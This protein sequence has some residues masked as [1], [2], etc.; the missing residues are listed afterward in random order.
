MRRDDG[1]DMTDEVARRQVLKGLGLLAAARLV[2]AAVVAPATRPAVTVKF[3]ITVNQALPF[4]QIL[5]MWEAAEGLG[6]DG[7]FVFDHFMGMSPG[8]PEQERQQEAWTLLAALA[9]RTR[10]LR[11]GLLVNGCT[12]RHPAIVAKMAATVDQ[13][14]RG[15]LIL[16]LGAGWAER[17]HKAYGIPFYTKAGRARRLGEYV[18]V[19]KALF[20]EERVT[21]SGKY[22][23]LKDAVLEPKPVQKPHPPILIGGS[24]KKIILPIAAK[25]AQ[26]WHFGVP[27]KDPT[28]VKQFVAAFDELC[29]S[30]GR[31]P[32]EVVKA[33]SFLL[34]DSEQAAKDVRALLPGLI[35]AGIT[36]FVLLP[37]NAAASNVTLLRKFARDFF[38]KFRR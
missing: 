25:Y 35:A 18:E 2:P 34:P 15:R 33:T 5:S 21:Y 3:S 11:V 16:G 28:V 24:G 20:V 38:P 31:N 14:S 22:F 29:R 27:S 26:M 32:A 4:D 23:Q 12:Y 9:A 19:I 1:A 30:V 10:R 6:F 13:I 17:E 8:T 7:A 36:Y 37:R